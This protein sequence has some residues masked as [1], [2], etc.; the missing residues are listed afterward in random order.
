[1]RRRRLLQA[2]LALA[3]GSLASR[4]LSWARSPG[5]AGPYPPALRPGSR[6]AALAPGTWLDPND[7]WLD[8]LSRRCTAQGWELVRSPALQQRWRWFA[9]SDRHRDT[10]WRKAWLD[11]QVD[12][13]FYV[14]AGW[15]SARV[16]EQGWAIPP[17]SRWCVGFSDCSALLLAQWAA[18]SAGG[19]HGWFGGEAAQWQRLVDL[20]EHRP[21]AP[22]QGVGV[23]DGVAQGPL[24]VSNLTIATSLIGTPWLPPLKGAI[25]VLED[26]G[27]APYRID[28]QLTQWR[29]SGLLEGVAGIGLGRFSWAEDDVLPGDFSMDE[30]L[31]ERLK[32]LGVPLVHQLPVGHGVPNLAL[33]LGRQA[34]LDG[35]TGRL[36]LLT[37]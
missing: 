3:G 1:M 26:T 12:A 9:G 19:I 2:G 32:P 15:G 20:L 31:L 8:Q 16:L 22:L 17:Q 21:V 4:S 25:L 7:P 35:R 5:S 27:E 28:R 23:Q 34:E 6:I 24:V 18:G 11:P 29:S 13:L 10:A 37:A 30:I 14:G 33:P 36:R